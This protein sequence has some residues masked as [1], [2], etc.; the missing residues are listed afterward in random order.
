MVNNITNNLYITDGQHRKLDDNSMN[1][2]NP[3]NLEVYVSSG[4]RFTTG[5]RISF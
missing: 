2:F 3:K 1:T 4:L 5:V